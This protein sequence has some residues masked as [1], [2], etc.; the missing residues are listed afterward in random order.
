[1]YPQ[2]GITCSYNGDVRM[3]TVGEDYVHAV[4]AAGGI[5]VLIPHRDS[6]QVGALL[7]RLDGLLL[8]GGG[9]IDPCYYG[10]EPLPVNGFI[11]PLR[12]SFEI[13]M[14]RKALE[15]GMPV[16]GICRGMQ[17]LNVA[18]GGSVCQDLSLLI[19]NPL[20]H[21][22]QAPRWYPTHNI[23][24]VKGSQL[25]NILNRDVVRVNSFHHQMVDVI[26]KDLVI[27]ALAEDRVVEA[28]EHANEKFFALGVQFHPE[29]MYDKYP[30]LSNIFM[31]FI[32]A[33]TRF[34]SNKK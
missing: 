4:Q 19:N 1:M 33:S 34:L 12:D 26:G 9:D 3:F 24:P 15:L 14:T 32:E 29:N 30:L 28:I 5:P 6:D 16:L 22:Q 7:T 31:A 25:H 8:S 13:P 2:I 23:K 11:D 21:M 20:Q 27:S 17:V 10:Q 18:A